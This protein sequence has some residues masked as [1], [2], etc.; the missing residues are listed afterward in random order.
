MTLT[1]RDVSTRLL[2]LLSLMTATG[3]SLASG[4]ESVT[5]DNGI[6]RNCECIHQEITFNASPS[7]VYKA[8]TDPKQFGKVTETI[9]PGAAATTVISP[10]VGGEFSMFKGII[11]G[12]HIEM[13]P[14][15]RLV[16]AWREK[17]WA[18]GVFSVVRFLLIPDGTRTKLVFDHTGFPQG[19]A[20]HLSVGWKSHYWEPL[21]KYFADQSK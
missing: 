21:Q 20:D 2:R 13:V 9:M 12:R 4:E 19:A 16:Q 17:D 5:S 1:R 11:L 7:R 3:V 10:Q 8:L 15:Q 14:N 6:S 18:P